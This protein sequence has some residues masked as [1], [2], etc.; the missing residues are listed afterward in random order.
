[1]ENH[2]R[3]WRDINYFYYERALQGRER[4]RHL[5]RS[6]LATR[7]ADVRWSR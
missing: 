1:M 4:S 7:G 5:T 2:D 6:A 3:Y